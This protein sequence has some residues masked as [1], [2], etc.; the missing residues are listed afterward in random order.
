ML[1]RTTNKCALSGCNEPPL[2]EIKRDIFTFNAVNAFNVFEFINNF[3][4]HLI[5]NLNDRIR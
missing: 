2:V 4:A 1:D 5:V 3:V